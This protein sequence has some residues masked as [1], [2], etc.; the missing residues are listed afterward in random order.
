[1][2]EGGYPSPIGP[3]LVTLGLAL[4]DDFLWFDGDCN[5]FCQVG[6][7]S[8]KPQKLSQGIFFVFLH[9]FTSFSL[10]LII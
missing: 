2:G 5:P 1:M 10:G 8:H 4:L 3:G 6:I 9:R 7:F